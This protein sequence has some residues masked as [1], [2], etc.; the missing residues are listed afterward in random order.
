VKRFVSILLLCA[1]VGLNMLV[2]HG[3]SLG[4]I[5]AVPELLSY[6]ESSGGLIPPTMEDGPTEIEMG[7][8]NG[9]GNPD[10]V[11]IGDHGSPY[12]NTDEH[13]VMVWFGDGAGGW[14]V[15]QSGDFGY[16]GIALGDVNNDGLM[17]VG[18]GMHHNHSGMDFG[19]QLMEVALGDGTGMNWTP[20]DDGLATHGEWWGM[21]GSDFADVDHDGDLD[22]GEASFGCCNGIHVYLNHGDGNWD[23][24]WSTLET[25]GYSNQ[26]FT[27]GDVNGDGHPDLAATYAYGLVYLGDG[28]GIFSLSQGNLPPASD[29]LGVALG[30]VNQDGRDELAIV[31]GNRGVQVWAWI[32]AGTWQNISGSLPVSG[33]YELVQ[34]ADMDMDGYVDVIAF[35]HGQVR[36]WAG[37]GSGGWTQVASF[38]T[39]APGYAEALRVGVDVDHNSHPDI[40]LVSDEGDFN[41]EN[42]LRFFKEGSTPETLD[43]YPVAPSINKSYYAGSVAFID[44]T[45]GIPAGEAGV[46]D[47]ELSMHGSGGPWTSITSDQPN[48]GRYQWL[49]AP[50]TPSTETAS[51][52]YSLTVAGETVQ[53]ITPGAFTIIGSIEEPIDGLAAFND[54][55]T[56]LN[57]TTMLS[58]TVIS[59]TNVTYMWN[60][61]DGTTAE[62]A[63]V[64]HVYPDIGFYTATVTATNSVSSDIATTMVE[65]YEEPISGLQA[66][67]DS[68]TTLGETTSLTATVS[69]G[70]NVIF[71]WLD[72]GDGTPA[73]SATVSHVY[74]ETGIYTA[75]VVAENR[76]GSSVTTTQVVIIP[77]NLANRI[78]LPLVTSNQGH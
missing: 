11:S 12:V 40:A 69:A 39:P 64:N 5:T 4:N 23:Q 56:I 68:P 34:L 19:D 30:D 42:H 27:F 74:P 73:D 76:A 10:I 46:V 9:D 14:N 54:S 55:P 61:G 49:I 48:N 1:W 59:G 50:G 2:V 67:N 52:R 45:S 36:I 57:E 41:S 17:D 7:D 65:V 78:W 63:S 24:S 15:H 8:V 43:I 71:A 62:G 60:L 25:D 26:Q 44:W 13:G 75:T 58:A 72:L 18:Y 33:P 51:I 3:V 37:D 70:S 53:S 77:P 16:G 32:S 21:F 38:T 29:A 20:W 6:V 66:I 28:S 35:G 47:L 31:R 22:L